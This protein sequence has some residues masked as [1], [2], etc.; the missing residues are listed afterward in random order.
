[1]TNNYG[2][3]PNGW[4]N[5]QT[6]APYTGPNQSP[7]QILPRYQVQR[8]TEQEAMDFPMGPN[9]SIFMADK[10]HPNRIFLVLTDDLGYK[11]IKAINGKFENEADNTSMDAIV[12]R[13][14]RLEELVNERYNSRSS[15]SKQ[16]TTEPGA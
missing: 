15:K 4:M 6:N 11:T 13:L 7:P 3:S 1:M 5:G 8:V 9:S 10:E 14:D 2:P 12:K 16:P